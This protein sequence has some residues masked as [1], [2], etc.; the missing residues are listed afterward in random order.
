MRINP[1]G[2]GGWGGGWGEVSVSLGGAI[3]LRGGGGGG[4]TNKV[5]RTFFS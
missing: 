1:K 2:G 4:Q 3:V 5:N